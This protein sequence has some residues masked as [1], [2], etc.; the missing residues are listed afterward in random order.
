MRSAR[1]GCRALFPTAGRGSRRRAAGRAIVSSGSG[2]FDGFNIGGVDPDMAAAQPVGGTAV[3]QCARTAGRGFRFG[4][5]PFKVTGMWLR[6]E[7][8]AFRKL[9]QGRF[10]V[11]PFKR[12]LG[13]G[14]PGRFL[15]RNRFWVARLGHTLPVSDSPIDLPFDSVPGC[16]FQ[17][18]SRIESC[19]GGSSIGE[20][21]KPGA[22]GPPA[23]TS[24]AVFP[25]NGSDC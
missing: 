23:P 3:D 6:L 14:G 10:V 12:H 18:K 4:P 19:F 1:T 7:F 24:P 15:I 11:N 2:Q 13:F 20:T 9:G 21:L 8:A 16:S 22:N 5:L 25:G 17:R